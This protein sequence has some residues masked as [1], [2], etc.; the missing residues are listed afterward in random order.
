MAFEKVLEN[1]LIEAGNKLADPPTSVDELLKLLTRVESFLSRVEQAPKASMQAALSPCLKALVADKLLRHSDPDVKVALASCIS[2]IT[3]I[4]APEAPYDDDQMKEIFQL[5]VSS[6]E[7]LHDKS[8]RSYVKRTAILE[9]VAKVRSCVVMLDL[10]CDALILEMFQHFLKAIREHH[11]G[12]VFSSMETIMTLV[13]EESEDISFDLLSPLLDSIKK[14]N[15]EVLPIARK[16][17][18]SVLKNCATK[19]K[20]YLVQAVRTIGISVDDYSEVLAS[21]CQETSDSLEKN[22]VCVTDEH[23]EDKGKSAKLSLEESTQVAKEEVK[24]A[25][26]LPQDNRDGNRSSKSVTNNGVARVGE[27]DTFADSKSIKKKEDTDSHGHSKGLHILGHG[28][29]NDLDGVKVNK[30]EQKPEQATKKNRRK[31]SYSTKSGK[32]SE[33]QIVTNE[34]EKVMVSESH[35]KEVLVSLPK[36]QGRNDESEVVA[37]A[38]PSDSLPNE[39]HS[40]KFGKAKSKDS[41]ANVEAAEVVSKKA[42]EGASISKPKLGKQSVKKLPGQNSGVKKSAGTD[43]GKKQSGAAIGADAKQHSAKK[44]D[45]NEG[46]G[47]SSSRQLVDKKKWGRGEANSGTGAAKSSTLDVDKE[48]VSS[49]RSDTES[50][51][52]EKLEETTKTSAKRKRASVKKNE[53]LIKGYDQNLVGER[54]EVWWPKDRAFYKGVIESFDSAKKK[55]KVLY[56]DGEVEV[57]NLVKEKWNIIEDDSVADEEEGS[58]HGSLDA[59]TEMHTRKKAK[60]I[61]GEQTKQGKLRLSSSGASGSSKSKGSV[62]KSG[63]KSNY[64]NKSKIIGSSKTSKP[65]DDDP[66]TPKSGASNQKTPKT[67]AAAAEGK[68]PK[69]GGKSSTADGRFSLKKKYMEDDDSDDSAREEVEY[70]KG[71]TSTSSKGQGSEAKTGKKRQRS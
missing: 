20:P 36:D 14:D 57:L 68:P 65:K 17:G 42:S 13:I 41:P 19:V 5:V 66:I 52:D 60:S 18:E 7:K 26:H 12:R 8:S 49:P 9:T 33:S 62:L 58:D 53:S 1:E 15:E 56:D 30:N 23:K 6:F 35:S 67:A 61:S 27:D 31:S 24:E 40:E 39:N 4:S 64:G 50:S 54:V 28:E 10:E 25:A 63:Q 32:L 43:S 51:E 22:G 69:S 37:S 46:G 70:T 71:K 44:F 38:S 47:G 59:S 45:D 34:D 11:Q 55:H 21:I 2:E 3:R 16:L 29:V 48:M